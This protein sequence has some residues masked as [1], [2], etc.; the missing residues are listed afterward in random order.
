M[1]GAFTL[2]GGSSVFNTN[3]DAALRI[4]SKVANPTPA[5]AGVTFAGGSGA[6]I[7]VFAPAANIKISTGASYSGSFIGKT[8]AISG[9]S[10]VNNDTPPV[11]YEDPFGDELFTDNFFS[12]YSD[13][14]DC[15]ASGTCTAVAEVNPPA[16]L[17][18]ANG[19]PVVDFTADA[20]VGI[21]EVCYDVEEP[22]CAT[23]GYQLCQLANGQ[24][25]CTD[26][27][28]ACFD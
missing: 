11:L 12:A 9:S 8:V 4:N 14:F 27:T 2:S 28:S 17:Y 16:G 22:S 24:Y 13:P 25:Q 26:V 18:C 21:V 3:A 15:N 6:N 1:N 7:K 23:V 19:D 20:F 5:T 10:T